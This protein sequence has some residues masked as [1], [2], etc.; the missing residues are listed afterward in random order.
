MMSDVIGSHVPCFRVEDRG[1]V[2]SRHAILRPTLSQTHFVLAPLAMVV[3]IEDPALR[4]AA[5]GAI[6]AAAWKARRHVA[7]AV[8]DAVDV[9]AIGLAVNSKGARSQDL[10][11]IHIDCIKPRVIDRLGQFSNLAGGGWAPSNVALERNPL[12]VMHV[13]AS[14]ASSLNPFAELLKLP[15]SMHGASVAGLPDGQGG[16]LLFAFTDPV[17]GAEELLDHSCAIANRASA[18]GAT[19]RAGNG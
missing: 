14:A 17:R 1:E 18:K 12:F 4:G 13:G 16:L 11:H 8:G 9:N 7:H 5:G 6:W 10:L 19:Q 15:P 3:G 2:N